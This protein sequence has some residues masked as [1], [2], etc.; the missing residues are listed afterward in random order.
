V[1]GVEPILGRALHR[2]DDKSGAAN[3]LVITHGLWQR[4]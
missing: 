2:S 4:R 1:T 3:V